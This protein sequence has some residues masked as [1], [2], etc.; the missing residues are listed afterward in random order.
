M[1][2]TTQTFLHK[3]VFGD[4]LSQVRPLEYRRA[5]WHELNKGRERSVRLIVRAM[6]G[7]PSAHVGENEHA[8]WSFQ[9][10]S[11]ALLVAY[12]L[13]GSVMELYG[14][15]E[16]E[17]EFQEAVDFLITEVSTRLKQL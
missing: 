5:E 3:K 14:N 8:Q 13:R 4:H 16:E 7:V 9:F 11:G 15:Q 17:Q 2:F 1:V 6:L 12:L 10:N